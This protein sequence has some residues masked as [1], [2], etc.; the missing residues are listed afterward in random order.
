MSVIQVNIN[1]EIFVPAYHHLLTSDADMD[2][3]YGGRDGAKSHFVAQKSILDCL[4]QSY[5]RMV[6]IKETYE[7]IKD[8][9]FKTIK[10]IVEEWGL[11]E[12]FTFRLSPLEI[13]CVNSNSF[14]ARGCDNPQKLKSIR[15]PSHAW[16]EEGNQLSEEEYITASTS[17]RSDKGKV[18]E[19]LTFNPEAEGDYKQHWIYKYFYSKQASR[20]YNNFKAE[21]FI[22]IPGKSEAVKIVYTSTHTTYHDNPYCPLERQ[23]KLEDLKETNPYYYNVYT[24]GKWGVKLVTAPFL[25]N[26]DRSRHEG[27]T[28]WNPSEVTY[29][30]FDFNKNPICCSVWQWYNDTEK[31]NQEW[32]YCIE[33]IK[34]PHSD[35]FKL[36]D[37]IR[38]K[39]PDALFFVTGDRS[40]LD[41]N[42]LVKDDVNYYDIIQ[43]ELDL[44]DAVIQVVTNPR[45]EENQVLCNKI[46][47]KRNVL[48]D[49][50]NC[51]SLIFDC[52]F[53][54]LTPEGK[55]KKEN[56][57]DPTQQAD[58]LD[59]MRYF[60]NRYIKETFDE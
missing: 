48:L 38:A 42:A 53:V 27:T 23:A 24:L 54:Q 51:Q 40:G 47:K 21:R 52:M 49:S 2:I 3:L 39:Y 16:Y 8:S 14:L 17:L 19:Y 15:N 31:D 5:F 55:I 25:F 57:D 9:Q 29:L 35:I 32:I 60:F 56:R 7:S 43:A 37:V 50:E 26:F 45:I 22:K 10:E 41:S 12:F 6:L 46:L 36:C 4:Q 59:T 13:E 34:L 33:C 28:I 20:L 1:P 58:A 30:S 18:K 11:S 44:N